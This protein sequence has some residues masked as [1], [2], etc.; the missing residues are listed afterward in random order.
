MRIIDRTVSAQDVGY[1]HRNVAAL[2]CIDDDAIVVR[3][4]GKAFIRDLGAFADKFP[5]EP[6]KA[7]EYLHRHEGLL[8]QIRLLFKLLRYADDQKGR[9]S[10]ELSRIIRQGTREN[11]CDVEILHKD[12]LKT[13]FI[14]LLQLELYLR[15]RYGGQLKSSRTFEDIRPSV[16]LFVESL[17]KQFIHEYYW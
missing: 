17:D 5:T 16:D 13:N 3:Y 1:Q 8:K 15:S 6:Q 12:T 4:F 14:T 11:K 2:G 9:I 7:R 10:P